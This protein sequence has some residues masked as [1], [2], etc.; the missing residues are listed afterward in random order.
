[1]N[2]NRS[3]LPRKHEVLEIFSVLNNEIILPAV[4]VQGRC[5]RRCRRSP[6][7]SRRWHRPCTGTAGSCTR[8]DSNCGRVRDGSS[9][10]RRHSPSCTS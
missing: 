1:M 4:P 7:G 8:A 3:I 9:R 5:Q 2:Q 10:S 6:R